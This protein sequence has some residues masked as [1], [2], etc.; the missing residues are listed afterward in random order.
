MYIISEHINIMMILKIKIK[1]SIHHNNL[2]TKNK[3]Y[4][5]IEVSI[6]LLIAESL[7]N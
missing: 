3:N 4:C 6:E 7:L 2:Y 5:I 1:Y